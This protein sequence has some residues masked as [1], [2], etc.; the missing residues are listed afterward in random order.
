[1]KKRRFRYAFEVV[2]T[3]IIF[4]LLAIANILSG[5]RTTAAVEQEIREARGLTETDA[6]S[7]VGADLEEE[8]ISVKKP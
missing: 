7:L 1:M 6:P 2:L 4:T 8:V 5:A 3:I